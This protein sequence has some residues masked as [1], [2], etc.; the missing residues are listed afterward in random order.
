MKYVIK[1]K[2]AP[3]ATITNGKVRSSDNKLKRELEFILGVGGQIEYK[4]GNELVTATSK[5]EFPYAEIES[6]LYDK[7]KKF[8]LER[9]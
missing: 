8:T 7:G 9:I 6:Y 1:E 4:R 3:I 2:G 5:G